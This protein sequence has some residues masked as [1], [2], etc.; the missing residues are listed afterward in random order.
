MAQYLTREQILA[1]DDLLTEDVAVP[2]WG[3]T[4][5]VR[6][7]TGAERDAFEQGTI[8]QRGRKVKARL[9]NIRARLASLCIV[10]E[11]GQRLFSE[12]D[13]VEL[14]RKSARPLDRVW[15]TATRLSG[16]SESDAEDLELNFEKG[17]S[18]G[19]GSS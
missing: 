10:D 11:Q 13:M 12:A 2:E 17:Q 1:A 7:L 6:G 9:V 18:G 5:R 4:V 16:M 8:E 19:P 15:D 14:G 3:G